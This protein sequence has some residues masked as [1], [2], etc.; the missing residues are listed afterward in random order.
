MQSSQVN[1]GSPQL[2]TL[3]KL[4]E[5]CQKVEAELRSEVGMSPFSLTRIDSFT[6]LESDS[7]QFF[8]YFLSNFPEN[9]LNFKEAHLTVS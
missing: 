1:V 9:A 4:P 8:F 6:L 7:F 3:W 2:R 5:S